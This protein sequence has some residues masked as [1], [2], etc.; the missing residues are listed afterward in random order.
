MH[1]WGE[2]L[3]LAFRPAGSRPL[4]LNGKTA[5]QGGQVLDNM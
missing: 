3:A 5:P 1:S 2:G 4:T